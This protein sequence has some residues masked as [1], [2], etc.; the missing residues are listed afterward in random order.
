MTVS[1]ELKKLELDIPVK[2]LKSG[3]KGLDKKMYKLLL[4]DRNPS[5][6]FQLVNYKMKKNSPVEAVGTLSLAGVTRTISLEGDVSVT[7]DEAH[8]LHIQ[9]EKELLMSD[10][11]IEPPTMLAGAL[12]TDDRVIVHYNLFILERKKP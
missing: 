12:K 8:S 6:H 10:F 9:G 5:I 7:G 4:A 2:G 11:N 3:K 1:G